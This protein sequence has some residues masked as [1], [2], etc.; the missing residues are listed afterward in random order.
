[1][2]DQARLQPGLVGVRFNEMRG[3]FRVLPKQG[4]AHSF[5][6]LA[7]LLDI[8][9][10]NGYRFSDRTMSSKNGRSIRAV[11]AQLVRAPVCGTG[12]RWFEPTQ[13]YQRNQTLIRQICEEC[14]PISALGSDWEAASA[15]LNSVRP[16][17]LTLGSMPTCRGRLAKAAHAHAVLS[18]KVR[19]PSRYLFRHS[20]AASPRPNVALHRCSWVDAQALQGAL[21]CI[22]SIVA[23]AP[24]CSHGRIVGV[25]VQ[26][27]SRPVSACMGPASRM[28]LDRAPTRRHAWATSRTNTTR[29]RGYQNHDQLAF[30]F[31]RC[32]PTLTFPF[33]WC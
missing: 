32:S 20:S 25:F 13:L 33:C 8:I 27:N 17:L 21:H 4:V 3:R 7:A 31:Q 24:R 30:G 28:R 1:M 16:V 9:L 18:K 15:Q 19:W 10:K 29:R 2:I 22:A 5:R 26:E 14:F 6:P 11:V 23:S 12:G